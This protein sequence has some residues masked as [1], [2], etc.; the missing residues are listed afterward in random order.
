MKRLQILAQAFYLLKEEVDVGLRG[1]RVRD[2][3]PEEVGLVPLRLVA[4]HGR[5][6][7]H[8]QGFDFGSHLVMETK[9]NSRL[10]LTP[11]SLP[12][13]PAAWLAIKGAVCFSP[14]VRPLTQRQRNILYLGFL[15]WL[16]SNDHSSLPRHT[17]PQKF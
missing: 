5:A 4:N 9:Q 13:Q 14:F 6:G 7:L 2:D 15:Q 3:H 12:V 16:R 11:L 8:H 17:F 10:T 1:G